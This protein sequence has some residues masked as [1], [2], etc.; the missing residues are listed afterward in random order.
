MFVFM[1]KS[2]ILEWQIEMKYLA[3]MWIKQVS[4]IKFGLIQFSNSVI[5]FSSSEE[6]NSL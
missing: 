6:H 1:Y 5:D 3:L 4:T 2:T